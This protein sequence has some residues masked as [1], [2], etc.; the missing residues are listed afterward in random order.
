[1]LNIFSVWQHVVCMGLDKNNIPDEYLCE[2]CS[3]RP[4][5]RFVFQLETFS[6]FSPSISIFLISRKRAKALQKARAKEI[7]NRMQPQAGPRD[8]SE[9][10][11]SRT[12]SGLPNSDKNRKPFSSL[13]GSRKFNGKKALEKK[14]LEGKKL[15]KKPHKRRVFKEG[16]GPRT[17]SGAGGDSSSPG[18]GAGSPTKKTGGGGG[19]LSPRKNLQRKSLSATDAETE[20]EEAQG[21]TLSLRSV[22]TYLIRNRCTPEKNNMLFSLYFSVIP[23]SEIIEELLKMFSWDINT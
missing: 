7:Y 21:E 9:D 3:P 6:I 16:S 18:V 12:N 14:L 13:G 22:S 4:I 2:K 5:D 20:P 19:S 17:N 1:M 15:L 11:K 8:S 23:S 10:E